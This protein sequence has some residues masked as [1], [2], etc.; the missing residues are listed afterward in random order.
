[1]IQCVFHVGPMIRQRRII[2]WWC[3][4]QGIDQRMG[5]LNQSHNVFDSITPLYSLCIKMY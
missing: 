2:Q 3:V 4:N 5:L 1:M